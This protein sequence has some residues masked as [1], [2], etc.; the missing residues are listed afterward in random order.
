MTNIIRKVLLNVEFLK[1]LQIMKSK[2]APA[3]EDVEIIIPISV[4]ENPFPER[5][6][7]VKKVIVASNSVQKKTIIARTYSGALIFVLPPL[8]LL[9]ILILTSFYDLNAQ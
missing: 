3:I 1:I 6:S 5:I 7:G 9:R 4:L 2:I 8:Y